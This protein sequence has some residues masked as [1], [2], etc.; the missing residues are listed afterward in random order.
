MV[1]RHSHGEIRPAGQFKLPGAPTPKRARIVAL[2]EDSAGDNLTAPVQQSSSGLAF[3]FPTLR[4][5]NDRLPISPAT[6]QGLIDLAAAMADPA[7]GIVDQTSDIP[8]V[9]TYFGQFLDHDISKIEALPGALDPNLRA[10]AAKGLM[11]DPLNQLENQRLAPLDLDS[12]YTKAPE[13][14]G[15]SGKLRLGK[16]S[17]NPIG[18]QFAVPGKDPENDLPRNPRSSDEKFDRSAQIGDE[19]NDE[20]LIVAQ[21]HVAFLR[22]HNALVVKHGDRLKAREEL[23]R[24]YHEIV[25][26]DFLPRIADLSVLNKVLTSGRSF[27]NPAN[28]ADVPLEHAGAAYRFGHSMV[29]GSYDFNLNFGRNGKLIA[30]ATRFDLLFV[31]TALSGQLG[32]AQLVETD[33]LPDNW[34]IDWSRVAVTEMARPIDTIISPAMGDLRDLKGNPLTGGMQFLAERNLLRGY[35]FGLPTG[36]AVAQGIGAPALKGEALLDA[37]PPGQR[38]A[39]EMF[40]D[41]SPLWFYI[42]AE[43]GANGGKLGV[44][45]ST[46]VIETLHALTEATGHPIPAAPVQGPSGRLLDLLALSGNFP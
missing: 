18:P 28:L 36:Q 33:T 8:A 19:R 26:T 29:R 15:N 38:D 3:M 5:A 34:I 30:P 7:E 13:D 12:V 39:A 45:G 21:L 35:V 11:T 22:A 44:V 41:A 40:K 42:L 20:N 23:T 46:I 14:Q 10:A 17:P 37:L 4:N 25:F 2:K 1:V 24:L 9:Y 32:N 43:A 16:V 6:V 27:W 31:F